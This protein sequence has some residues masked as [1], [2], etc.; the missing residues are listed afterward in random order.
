MNKQKLDAYKLTSSVHTLSVKS[1]DHVKDVQESVEDC[2]SVSSTSTAAGETTTCIIN[3][4]KLTGDCLAYSEF[5]TVIGTILAGA[6]IREYRINRA[7]MRFDS[8]DGDHYERFSKLNRYLISALATTYKTKNNYRATDLFSDKQLSIAVK[9]DYFEAENYDRSAKSVITGNTVEPAKSRLELRTVSRQWRKINEQQQ[10]RDN[11]EK[12]KKDMTD[13]WFKRWDKALQNLSLVHKKY[14]D[15]L[16]QIY[17]EGKSAYPKKFRS[18]TDFLIQYQNSIFCKTQMIELLS[19]FP[20]VK[21]PKTR[22][23]NHKKRYGIEY[24]SQADVRTAIDEVKRAA[25]EFFDN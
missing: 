21:D 25:R 7:D 23:E 14:N 2:I 13:T 8:Y 4:N 20:E 16:E 11:L 3:P 10:D 5:Q 9:N 12:L 6:G 18:L 24:F 17:N 1:P 22:A 15:A 19:R